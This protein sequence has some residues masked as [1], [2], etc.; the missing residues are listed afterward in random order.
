MATI[1]AMRAVRA[2]N[3]SVPRDI[4]IVGFDDFEWVD[5]FEPGLT[6]MAQPCEEI[7]RQAAV[8]LIERIASVGGPRRT[9][10]LDGTLTPRDSCGRPA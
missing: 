4:S 2:L 3:L 6:V 10:R 8:L 9:I 1:G 7:G 5:C